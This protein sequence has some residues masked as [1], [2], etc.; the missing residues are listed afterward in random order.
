M[1][2]AGAHRVAALG[3]GARSH[4]RRRRPV[5][6][7]VALEL[8]LHHRHGVTAEATPPEEALQP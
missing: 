4:R 1:R 5:A 7:C 8:A 2:Q 6:G 3:P